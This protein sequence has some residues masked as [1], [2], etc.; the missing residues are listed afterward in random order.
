M[1]EYDSYGVWE[2]Q[3]FKTS[4][5]SLVRWDPTYRL[6]H[7]PVRE[8]M[9][10]LRVARFT[11]DDKS[12]VS[13]HYQV[14]VHPM[15]PLMQQLIDTKPSNQSQVRQTMTIASSL[16]P[17]CHSFTVVETLRSSSFSRTFAPLCVVGKTLFMYS[18]S[19]K[20]APY[21][22]PWPGHMNTKYLTRKI[23]DWH[24][25]GHEGNCWRKSHATMHVR[26][27]ASSQLSTTPARSSRTGSKS[28]IF[29][30][31]LHGWFD[32]ASCILYNASSIQYG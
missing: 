5:V 6:L 24:R 27:A 3:S 11:F 12:C 19:I 9:P 10:Y 4:V 14:R 2:I 1:Y 15:I 31:P 30:A 21:Y 16:E 18:F 28:V 25:T 13:E 26:E 22:V 32:R 23:G 8:S 17:K 29:C 20:T 7:Q